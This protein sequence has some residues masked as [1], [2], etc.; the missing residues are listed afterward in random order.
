MGAIETCFKKLTGV[1]GDYSEQQMLDCGYGQFGANGCDGARTYAY[2]AWAAANK[3]EF[4]HESNYPYQSTDSTF[5]CPANLPVYNQGARVSSYYGTPNSNEDLLKKL[6][7]EN[8]AVV[9]SINANTIGEYKG[10]IYE[11]CDPSVTKTNHA[12]L[13]VGYG[14]ENGVD[15]W[16]IKNSWGADWGE[17]G[18]M[19]LQRG[20]GMCGIGQKMY[21]VSCET[22]SGPTDAPLT[23]ATPCFDKWGNCPDIA[24]N[25]CHREQY[26]TECIK[27]CGLCAGMTPAKSN[28]CYDKYTS[29]PNY[30]SRCD[31]SNVAAACMKTCGKCP[32]AVSTTTNPITTRETT[33]T[34][35]KSTT[36]APKTTT[37]QPARCYDHMASHCTTNKNYYTRCNVSSYIRR[38][39]KKTCKVCTDN[40][41]PAVTT[42]A[43]P[44]YDQMASYCT[45]NP[46]YY[47][48]CNVSSYIRRVCKKTCKVCTDNTEP[49]T[50]TT[51][52][53]KT[54]CYDQMASYCTTNPNYYTRCNVSSYIRRVCKKTCKVC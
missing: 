22:T 39:C 47:T 37:A 8:S 3:I 26:K 32:K 44:C 5:Q 6:V 46:N 17:E 25:Y 43:K 36:L 30:A 31:E 38:V 7:H 29:C 40:T 54:N 42:T 28:Y 48:R 53:P 45:T 13:V 11:G 4:T 14:T 9:A 41:K 23:T 21:T 49:A 20:V 2:L 12:I 18:Y 16:L 35:T 15:Y 51:A 19:K 50:T 10:G 27:S 24:E 33:R 34:T 52:K 1:F